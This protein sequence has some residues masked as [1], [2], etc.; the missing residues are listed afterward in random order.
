MA[1]KPSPRTYDHRVEDYELED[2]VTGIQR[3]LDDHGV[4]T[5]AD[6]E[7]VL[8]AARDE[9]HAHSSPND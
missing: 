5:I 4:L 7:G 3:V 6:Y 2:L 8:K 1:T 9:A